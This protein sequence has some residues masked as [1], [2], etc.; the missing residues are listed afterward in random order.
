MIR[1]MARKQKRK[2]RL[3]EIDQFVSMMENKIDK[4]RADADKLLT[5]AEAMFLDGPKDDVGDPRISIDAEALERYRKIVYGV[6]AAKNSDCGWLQVKCAEAPTM[7][8]DLKNAII[9]GKVKYNSNYQFTS[10]PADK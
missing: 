10:V 5:T 9:Y 1:W 6:V 3:G 8:V 4:F 7:D 2:K